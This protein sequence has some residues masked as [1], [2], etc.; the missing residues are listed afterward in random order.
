MDGAYIPS[1]N[2]NNRH[3][4]YSFK[5][6]FILL[7]SA[8]N[9]KEIKSKE[10]QNVEAIFLSSLHKKNNNFLGINRFKLL[11]HLTN[12]KIVALGGIT[13]KNKKQLGLIDCSSFAGIS[14]FE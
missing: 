3:L 6:K 12:K 9:I 1:F 7:G 14:F 8:H 5:K 13:K 11:S 10:K 2:K 4:S